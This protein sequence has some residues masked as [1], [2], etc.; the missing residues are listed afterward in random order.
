MAPGDSIMLAERARIR[1]AQAPALRN[2]RDQLS[3]TE[4]VE[5]RLGSPACTNRRHQADCPHGQLLEDI[6]TLDRATRAKP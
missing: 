5:D 6:R 3:T 2:L 4:C 1:R